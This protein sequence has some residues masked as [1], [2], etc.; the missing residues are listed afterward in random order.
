MS[1]LDLVLLGLFLIAGFNGY[2]KGLIGQAASLAGLILGIWGA[3][4]FSDFTANFLTE[5]FSMNSKYLS[6]ISF[7]ITFAIILVAAH[8]IGFLVE[9]IF[10]LAFLGIVNSLLGVVFGVLKT[11][12]IISVL[13]V[14]LSGASTKLKIIPD[15]FG[16]N[17]LLYGPVKRLAPSIFPYLNFN[18]LKETI[19]TKINTVK[20]GS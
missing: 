19:Q 1:I 10:D 3:I 8:L 5:N 7:G 4:H 9:K 6:L 17:S 12:L 2:R 15:D 18:E 20:E 11:A 16:S 13:I 14:L